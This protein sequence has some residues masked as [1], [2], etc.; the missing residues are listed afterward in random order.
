MSYQ[1]SGASSDI[2]GRHHMVELSLMTER[3]PVDLQSEEVAFHVTQTIPQ[4]VSDGLF[5]RGSRQQLSTHAQDGGM[6]VYPEMA[7][8]RTNNLL[9]KERDHFMAL[10]FLERSLTDGERISKIYARIDMDG[11]TM[12]EFSV[13]L[14]CASTSDVFILERLLPQQAGESMSYF[15]SRLPSKEAR[16][17][18]SFGISEADASNLL[19]SLLAQQNTPFLVSNTIE[20][21][22]RQILEGSPTM[23]VSS[24]A[25]YDMESR[26]PASQ[27]HMQMGEVAIIGQASRDVLS[28]SIG[29]EEGFTAEQRRGVIKTKRQLSLEHDVRNHQ[30][31][32][33]ADLTVV[34]VDES[35]N[36]NYGDR[37]EHFNSLSDYFRSD[38]KQFFIT[39]GAVA[40]RLS[41]PNTVVERF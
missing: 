3:F 14:E 16:A 9:R 11:T 41:D 24:E 19:T 35:G 33:R 36:M 18:T 23:Y 27:L 34:I 29:I 4:A 25:E 12:Q 2:P 21:K 7:D 20:E 5:I 30:N 1:S 6:P 37:D 13:S 40:G 8:V 17:I 15:F 31:P 28:Y 32:Y 38:Q 10:R 22:V 39:L 26:K